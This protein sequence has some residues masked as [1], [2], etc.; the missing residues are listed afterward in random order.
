M[1]VHEA[2]GVLKETFRCWSEDNASTMAASLAY[3]T[4]FALAPLLIIVIEIG[5][6]L[7]GGP[8]HNQVVKSQLLQ[9]I[10]PYVGA[11]STNFISTLVDATFNQRQSQGFF[12]VTAGWVLFAIAATGLFGAVQTTLDTVWNSKPKNAGVLTTILL[13]AKSLVIIAALSIVFVF[14]FI[15]NAGLSAVS[16]LLATRIPGWHYLVIGGEALIAFFVVSAAFAA[17]FKF[18][19]QTPIAWRDVITGSGITGALFILG[20]YAIGVY[21]GRVSVGSTY[22]AA[23]SLVVL[24]V[25]LYYSGEIF[26]FGAEFTKVYATR[27]GSKRDERRVSVTGTV[28]PAPRE[29][30]TV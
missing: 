22:G 9:Q 24:L 11:S 30:A 14:S 16:G 18:L 28:E 20:Q 29:T 15:A 23:G 27:Y 12:A 17:L 7:L 8:G 5:A 26:L 21:L 19:P 4:I 25:W 1:R 10:Q 2:F 6:I 13:R 3:F